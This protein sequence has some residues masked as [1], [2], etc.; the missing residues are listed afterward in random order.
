MVQLVTLPGLNLDYP[1][2]NM[3][4]LKSF[5]EEH[6]I[7]AHLTDLNIQAFYEK[8]KKQSLINLFSDSPNAA[9]KADRVLYAISVINGMSEST[10]EVYQ[11]AGDIIRNTMM[12]CAKPYG[13]MWNNKG[14]HYKTTLNSYSIVEE[15]L[16]HPVFSFFDDVF[17]GLVSTITD[18][19]QYIVLSVTSQAQYPFAVRLAKKIKDNG[20]HRVIIT[21][22][23][24]P[25]ISELLPSIGKKA[26]WIDYHIIGHIEDIILDLIG[27]KDS[28]EARVVETNAWKNP[29]ENPSNHLCCTPDFSDLDM[30]VYLAKELV[31]PFQ[32]TNSCYYGKCRFCSF[33]YGDGS[34]Y[35]STDRVIEQKID[36]Y[37]NK[38]HAGHFLFVDR[39]IPASI[40]LRI[41]RYIINKSYTFKWLLETR[42]DPLYLSDENVTLLK[43]AGCKVISFGI[44]SADQ[45]LLNQMSKGIDFSLAE[46]CMRK[47]SEKGI[48]IASTIML[49]FFGESDGSLQ[50]TLTYLLNNDYLDLFGI[51]FYSVTKHSPI[52][53][54]NINKLEST[55]NKTNDMNQI[56][57]RTLLS[58]NISTRQTDLINQFFSENIVKQHMECVSK[59][60]CR[61]HYLF[62]PKEK[63]SFQSRKQQ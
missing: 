5:L 9:H 44:E 25:Y 58:E 48:C 60:F 59:T 15:S 29:E 14:I 12:E 49:L 42:I 57:D 24:L 23:F 54:E 1:D 16:A 20:S 19:D 31:L 55:V 7:K 61:S 38:Y 22:N 11:A 53:Y 52:Y 62:W 8:M 43:E 10:Y 35:C 36:T 45:E 63:Y 51:L 46:K 30:S 41:C 37:V 28:Q 6:Q 18:D 3:P 4:V 13:L 21:G 39:C 2:I 47:I 56:F 27:K 17:D 40:V 32:V 34:Y 50:R 26:W 33:H